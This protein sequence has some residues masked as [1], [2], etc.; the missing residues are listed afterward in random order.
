MTFRPGFAHRARHVARRSY[1][2][3]LFALMVIAVAVA[4]VSAAPAHR[5]AQAEA[6]PAQCGNIHSNAAVITK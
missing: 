1:E 2:V 5:R 6:A 3:A 4:A